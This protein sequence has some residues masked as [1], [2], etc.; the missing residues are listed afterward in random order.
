MTPRRAIVVGALSLAAASCGAG[1]PGFPATSTPAV[2]SLPAVTANVEV[3]G[4][5]VLVPDPP[6]DGATVCDRFATIE[7]TGTVNMIGL[8]EI[9]GVAASRSRPG[10]LWA[11]NDSG[12]AAAVTAIGAEGTDLGTWTLDGVSALDWED[13]ALGPGPDPALDYLYIGD[14]GDNL[15]FR[16]D[17]MVY[18]VPEPTEEGDGVITDVTRLR[19]VYPEPGVDAEALAVDPVTGDLLVVSKGGAD[20]GAVAYRA[21]AGR[22]GADPVLLL[23]PI[24]EGHG[25]R[26]HRRRDGRGPAR[27][28]GGVDVDSPGR[29][30]GRRVLR[31]AVHGPVAGGGPGRGPLLPGQRPRL[32]HGQRGGG[33]RRPP[34][35]ALIRPVLRTK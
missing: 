13:I 11:H 31:R 6:P 30:P 12:G 3:P 28:P 23:K 1:S 2:S 19:L 9:S 7:T 5:I 35:R 8:T 16:P 27:V 10:V 15:A 25:R 22:F 32:L 20:T 21:R 26:R 17:I 24:A 14:I 29:R 34:R 18:R 4:T 33:P